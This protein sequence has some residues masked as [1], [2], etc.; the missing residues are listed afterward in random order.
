MREPT[1]RAMATGRDVS[2]MGSVARPPPRTTIC[3]MHKRHIFNVIPRAL[4]VARIVE[5]WNATAAFSLLK[6]LKR[7]RDPA[8]LGLSVPTNQKPFAL[9]HPSSISD[10]FEMWGGGGGGVGAGGGLPF[11]WPP[12]M[13]VGQPVPQP[14]YGGPAGA[15]A[16]GPAGQY[17]LPFYPPAPHREWP[18]PAR[19]TPHNTRGVWRSWLWGRGGGRAR[20]PCGGGGLRGGARRYVSERDELDAWGTRCDVDV[21]ARP[22]RP[23]TLAGARA[24]QRIRRRRGRTRA[25]AAGRRRRPRARLQARRCSHD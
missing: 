15:Y 23:L 14:P 3:G 6:N 25:R 5:R 1:R 11:W 16:A 18:R 7:T 17:S 20:A 10:R 8:L 21:L 12:G 2:H 19:A 22:P 4:R 24:P 9:S 13:P